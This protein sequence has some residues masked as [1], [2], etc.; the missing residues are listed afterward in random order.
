MVDHNL[1]ELCSMVRSY[2]IVQAIYRRVVLAGEVIRFR[3]PIRSIVVRRDTKP[4]YI[5]FA[6]SNL[7]K[8]RT[9]YYKCPIRTLYKASRRI[10]GAPAA[11]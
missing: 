6:Y 7:I 5:H 2:P 4:G 1:M 10:P 9:Y 3:G 8:G 11:A